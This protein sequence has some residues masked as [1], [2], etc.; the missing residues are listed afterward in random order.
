M[1]NI[2]FLLLDEF[3]VIYLEDIL[4]FRPSWEVHI[5]HVSMVFTIF[6]NCCSI[7]RSEFFDLFLFGLCHWQRNT[8]GRANKGATHQALAT[9]SPWSLQF[10]GCLLI[11]ARSHLP[12]FNFCCTSPFS[13]Q[14]QSGFSWDKTWKDVFQ[15]LK[16]KISKAPI[17]LLP[18]MIIICIDHMSPWG[19]YNLLA[20]FILEVL[21]ND[22]VLVTYPED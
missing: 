19:L 15:L 8:W 5:Q 18:D 10:H 14:G 20:W 6:L 17:L 2:F 13:H 12:F 9:P 4:I 16:R 21:G 11:L 7:K 3:V 22:G 1:N